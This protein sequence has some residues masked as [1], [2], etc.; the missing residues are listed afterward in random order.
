MYTDTPVAQRFRTSTSL[1]G[2]G[3]FSVSR[4]IDAA[5]AGALASEDDDPHPNGATS[6]K[7]PASIAPTTLYVMHTGYAMAHAHQNM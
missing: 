1:L 3:R 6:K 4:S 7:H 2:G 5:D